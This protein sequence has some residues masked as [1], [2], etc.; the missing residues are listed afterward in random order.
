MIKLPLANIIYYAIFIAIAALTAFLTVRSIS[1]ISGS[2]NAIFT[3]DDGVSGQSVKVDT[4]DYL[5]VSKKLGITA[6]Q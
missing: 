3:V 5:L 2:I 1:F 4:E 6:Q